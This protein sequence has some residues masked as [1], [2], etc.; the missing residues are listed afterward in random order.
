MVVYAAGSA[1]QALPRA[2]QVGR[3]AALILLAYTA[4][5]LGGYVSGFLMADVGQ[6][7]VRDLRNQLFRHTLDQSAAFFAR[8]TSGQLVSRITNDV[9]QVQGVVSETV[10]DLVRESLSVIGYVS[11]M[12]YLDW[13]LALVVMTSAPLI[14][15][16][17]IQLGRRVRSTSRSGQEQLAQVTHIATEAMAG[18]RIVKAF[19]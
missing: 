6:R 9:N 15:Y 4:K 2:E 17:L 7:V 10:A 11:V 5:G 18:H 16:P 1:A 12:F 8:R 3:I 19:G 13:N 14:L